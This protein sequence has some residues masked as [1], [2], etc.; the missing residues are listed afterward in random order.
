MAPGARRRR[1]KAIPTF[2]LAPRFGR[3]LPLLGMQPMWPYTGSVIDQ[4]S[5]R[6]SIAST[7]VPLP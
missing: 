7:P 1:L 3:T 4:I 2:P 5:V 6:T